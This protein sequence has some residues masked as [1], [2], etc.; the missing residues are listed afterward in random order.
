M[1][2]T[3]HRLSLS[4]IPSAFGSSAV[5][6]NINVL[7]HCDLLAEAAGDDSSCDGAGMMAISL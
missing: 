4:L 7:A 5:R 1:P 6:A 2:P 3:H